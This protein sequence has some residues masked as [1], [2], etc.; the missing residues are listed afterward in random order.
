MLVSTRTM[1][2]RTPL[3]TWS[4]GVSAVTVPIFLSSHPETGD[5]I[6]PALNALSTCVCPATIQGETSQL[7][8][9]G[10]TAGCCDQS[11]HP[12]IHPSIHRPSHLDVRDD[13][14]DHVQLPLRAAHH[15]EGVQRV[16]AVEASRSPVS[17]TYISRLASSPLCARAGAYIDTYIHTYIPLYLPTGGGARPGPWRHPGRRS[18]RGTP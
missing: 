15:R 18:A 9:H 17:K 7:D 12:S 13:A 16:L 10:Q 2:A 11:I 1:D 5:S 4:T 14:H 8:G 6:L 3:F